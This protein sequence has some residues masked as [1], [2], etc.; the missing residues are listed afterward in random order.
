MKTLLI[1]L[2]TL[3]L[4]A[5]GC[6]KEDHKDPQTIRFTEIGKGYLIKDLQGIL[7]TDWEWR[8]FPSQG[9]TILTRSGT[10]SMMLLRPTTDSGYVDFQSRVCNECGYSGWKSQIFQIGYGSSGLDNPNPPGLEW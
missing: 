5:G 8:M 9:V 2:M 10:S 6:T 3:L 4:T 1:L 7:L